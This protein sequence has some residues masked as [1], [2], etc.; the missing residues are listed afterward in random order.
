MDAKRCQALRNSTK[1][2]DTSE[3]PDVT[4][5]KAEVVG[6]TGMVVKG[7]ASGAFR[8]GT[9]PCVAGWLDA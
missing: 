8:D 4:K 5:Y 6:K 2:P 7:F 3:V 1:V 9:R